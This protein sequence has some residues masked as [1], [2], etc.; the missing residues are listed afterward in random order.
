MIFL[1]LI[2]F[3]QTMAKFA[4]T[5]VVLAMFLYACATPLP[6]LLRKAPPTI[7]N[8]MMDDINVCKFPSIEIL[9]NASDIISL[10]PCAKLIPHTQHFG[11]GLTGIRQYATDV[12]DRYAFLCMGFYDLSIRICHSNIP[13]ESLMF[14]SNKWNAL[15]DDPSHDSKFCEH[16]VSV[17]DSSI[18]MNNTQSGFNYEWVQVL[19]ENLASP[20]DCQNLCI[21]KGKVIPICRMLL[22]GREQLHN[23]PMEP[24][25]PKHTDLG[26]VT[27]AINLEPTSHEPTMDLEAKDVEVG[28][29]EQD[30]SIAKT[31]DSETVSAAKPV[32][33]EPVS[34]AGPTHISQTPSE[35]LP[36]EQPKEKQEL[37][38]APNKTVITTKAPPPVV[39]TPKSENS[40]KTE[41]KSTKE[42]TKP[43][44]SVSP[45]GVSSTS[46]TS[47]V[48]QNTLDISQPLQSETEDTLAGIGDSGDIYANELPDGA[49][50]QQDHGNVEQ[51]DDDDDDL[52]MHEEGQ[53]TRQSQK[54]FS[55]VLGG[56][57]DSQYHRFNSFR[58]AE[59]SH[60]FAY[61]LTL[62]VIC[63][64]G[65]L[66]FHNKNKILALVLEG[67]KGPRGGRSSRRP[68]TSSY[69]KLDSTLEEAISSSAPRTNPHVI[70]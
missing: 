68:S 22:W 34:S 37:T 6:P 23:P 70:Y 17:T 27:A 28:T 57:T 65:Y 10:T 56:D 4:R 45:T 43:S 67:R 33:S 61:F 50:S 8:L 32:N 29:E 48:P 9:Q 69:R 44:S 3:R 51:D 60:F 31:F 49:T 24:M 54:E 16:I 46:S 39:V 30:L 13:K 20:D 63:I 62:S 36:P 40:S 64:I 5:L 53:L 47:V 19:N 1:N 11:P 58:D 21:R 18:A 38:P 55:P 26:P 66:V 41:E 59:D 15:F 35:E 25:E 12:D 52:T 2:N 14:D 7:L 42:T